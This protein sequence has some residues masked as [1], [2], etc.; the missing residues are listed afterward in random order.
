MLNHIDRH[1][2]KRMISSFIYHHSIGFSATQN[3]M[4]SHVALLPFSIT[5][6]RT[7][8]VTHL[9]AS[10]IRHGANRVMQSSRVMPHCR[11]DNP[12]DLGLEAE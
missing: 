10:R 4:D 6:R 9:S 7:K 3:E 5:D 11:L 8:L 12:E 2:A 1:F